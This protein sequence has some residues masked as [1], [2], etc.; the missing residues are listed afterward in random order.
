MR[1]AA[2]FVVHVARLAVHVARL[3]VHWIVVRVLG[4]VRMVVMIMRMVMM[5]VRM[6]VIVMV[7][8]VRRGRRS[9]DA[10]RGAQQGPFAQESTA[11]GQEKPRA[12]QGDQRIA[13]DLD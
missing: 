3:A 2:V 8:M 5:C 6:A 9:A 10:L 12:H 11:L 1:M 4:V 7:M 13:H